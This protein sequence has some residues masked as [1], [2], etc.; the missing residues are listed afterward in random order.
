MWRSLNPC[1]LLVIALLPVTPVYATLRQG[2]T[3]RVTESQEKYTPQSSAQTRGPCPASTIK[4]TAE[5]TEPL[6]FVSVEG[7]EVVWRNV[8]NNPAIPDL[9]LKYMGTNP[10]PEETPPSTVFMVTRTIKDRYLV[11]ARLEN[12]SY[13]TWRPPFPLKPT[14]VPKQVSTHK[15]TSTPRATPTPK[16]T[17]GSK[18]TT[19]SQKRGWSLPDVKPEK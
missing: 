18:P 13:G 2:R 16:P 9:R 8:Y 15:P 14:P 6:R 17:A 19:T 10:I 3:R 7:C 4:R 11:N 12:G 5:Q 1:L